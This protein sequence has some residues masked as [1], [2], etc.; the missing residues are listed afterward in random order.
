MTE[1][2][3]EIA[4]LNYTDPLAFLKVNETVKQFESFFE[5]SGATEGD[6]MYTSADDRIRVW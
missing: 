4:G 2:S 3:M 1:K 6:R 5:A